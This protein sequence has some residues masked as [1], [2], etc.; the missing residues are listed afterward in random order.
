MTHGRDNR[1]QVIATVAVLVAASAAARAQSRVVVT[2]AV[3]VG[4]LYD[5]NILSAETAIADHIWRVSPS[6]DFTRDGPRS[7]LL[8]DA[9]VDGEW[10]ARYGEFSTPAA[11]Q[12]AAVTSMW[13]TNA[14]TQISLAAGYDS[15][16]Y[17]NDITTETSL[18]LGRTRAWNVFAGPQLRRSLGSTWELDADYKLSNDDSELTPGILTQHM[19]A[20]AVHALAGRDEIRVR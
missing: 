7:N 16:L 10:F 9:A 4:T 17:P 1:W 12:H 3:S 11:R 2:P 14:V 8:G 13:K 18:I 19:G 6:I 20:G 15:S 5:G